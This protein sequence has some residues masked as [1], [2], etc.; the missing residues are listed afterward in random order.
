[1]PSKAVDL[2]FALRL[3]LQ[4]MH[5]EAFSVHQIVNTL[6]S[7]Y[8]KEATL[9][10]AFTDFEYSH[11]TSNMVGS[12]SGKS[13][14]ELPSS[15]E[16]DNGS[17]QGLKTVLSQPEGVYK[18]TCS[19]IG[20]VLPVDYKELTNEEGNYSAIRESCSSSSSKWQT[21][22][23]MAGTPEEMAKKFEEQSAIQRMQHE[24]LMAQ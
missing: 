16:S 8:F 14:S 19:R 17:F 21:F 9:A 23:Y 5:C 13:K 3:P 4:L 6:Q 2:S 11:V 7:Q 24:M 10:Q 1:M 20:V 18:H 22:A 15:G 12:K